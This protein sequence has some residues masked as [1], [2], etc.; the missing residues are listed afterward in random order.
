MIKL[1]SFF[2]AL[3]ILGYGS[4][5]GQIDILD[6]RTNFI[7]GDTVTVE[8]VVTS[9][10]DLGSVRYI[11]DETAGIAIYPGLDWTSFEFEPQP[12][13]YIVVNG[14]LTEYYGLLEVGSNI[15]SMTLV[16]SGNTLPNPQVV[17][18]SQLNEAQEGRWL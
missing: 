17:T 18:P 1:N 13:D 2:T 9:G 15:I 14:V 10:T 12:G 8:G 11:Q 6:A 7:E 16:S 4:L 5:L 3:A